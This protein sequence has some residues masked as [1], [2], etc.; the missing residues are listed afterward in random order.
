[1]TASTQ[2]TRR[3]RNRAFGSTRYIITASRPGR[4]DARFC[5]LFEGCI[6]GLYHSLHCYSPHNTLIR[7][8]QGFASSSLTLGSAEVMRGVLPIEMLRQ[9]LLALMKIAHPI[10]AAFSPRTRR[11]WHP[12]RILYLIPMDLSCLTRPAVQDG[13][14]GPLSTLEQVDQSQPSIATASFDNRQLEDV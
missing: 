3:N 6:S 1:M 10:L 13:T 9:A 7:S 4:N 5:A 14:W 2:T 8:S 11:S 12:G